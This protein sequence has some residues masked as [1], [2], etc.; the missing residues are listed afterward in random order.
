LKKFRFTGTLEDESLEQ[1][2]NVMSFTVPI[3]YKIKG[4]NVVFTEKEGFDAIYKKL[5]DETPM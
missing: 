1:V 2:L 3:N 4:K 5:N